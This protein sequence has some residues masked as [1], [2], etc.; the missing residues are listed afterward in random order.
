MTLLFRLFSTSESEGKNK[1]NTLIDLLE[2][3]ASVYG[4]KP[5]YIFIG[6]DET[7]T[8]RISYRE[9]RELAHSYSSYFR[10]R[11]AFGEHVLLIIPDED[12]L[13]PVFWGCA[14]A[15][16]VAIPT[17]AMDVRSVARMVPRLKSILANAGSRYIIATRKVQATMLENLGGDQ[18]EGIQW[19]LVEEAPT[20]KAPYSRE[21]RLV[22]ESGAIL[23][24]TSGSTSSPKGILLT[25]GNLMDNFKIVDTYTSSFYPSLENRI[26]VTWLP[27]FHDM[28][29]VGTMLQTVY[30]SY[31][32]VIM[33]PLDFLQR[34][35]RWLRLISKYR[36]VAVAAPNFAYDICRKRA[37]DEDII[38][39]DLSSLAYLMNGSETI[40]WNSLQEFAAKF[41]PCGFKMAAFAPVYGLAESTV[42]VTGA[43]PGQLSA[44]TVS[45]QS[46]QGRKPEFVEE[47]TK[48][49][50]QVV[51]CG[52]CIG[53]DL[54]IVDPVQCLEVPPGEIGEIW[55]S[56]K[57]IASGYWN[58]P[59]ET[60]KT[61]NGK[62]AIAPYQKFLRT[63]DLGFMIGDQLY[64]S[65]RIKDLIIVN[66]KN[67]Y[68]QD[69]E[70]T[71]E[72]AHSLIRPGCSVA[73]AVE[74]KDEFQVALVLEAKVPPRSKDLKEIREKVSREVAQVHGLAVHSVTLIQ[75]GTI[76]KTSSGK[77]QRQLTKQMWAKNSLLRLEDPI[78]RRTWAK[79]KLLR[80][81]RTNA[82]I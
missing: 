55:V 19:I 1:L 12:I 4:D 22:P 9:L 45:L 38:G 6:S 50:I 14:Y 8:K 28:G 29:L 51:S 41:A 63:G 69:L 18:L 81:M 82:G 21:V 5:V 15:G 61:F 39:L 62:L 34:P 16:I 66:G 79:L 11:I 70:L 74:V 64:F 20:D 33:K 53:Q 17:P 73:F 48:N 3:H 35:I 67:H 43:G 31:T 2:N 24:Y 26:C 13:L 76:F 52:S 65:G 80:Y 44:K 10:S 59:E 37:S 58:L 56:G 40:R 78:W 75:A 23:Q 71:A 27:Y 68:P 7:E 47:G 32:I 46:L 57:S 30:S 25:H 77:V 36:A 72:R 42:F 49:S 54:R 60:E